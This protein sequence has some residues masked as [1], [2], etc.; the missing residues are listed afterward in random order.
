MIKFIGKFQLIVRNVLT[1]KITDTGWL[2][3]LVLDNVFNYKY[4][5]ASSASW[6]IEL[7]TGST[8]PTVADLSLETLLISKFANNPVSGAAGS[9]TDF[10]SPIYSTSEGWELVFDLGEVIGNISEIGISANNNLFTR[11]L[12]TDGSGDPTT[13]TLGAND[14]LTVNYRLG[15]E[16]DTSHPPGSVSVDF[17][18]VTINLTAKW[19]DLGKGAACDNGMNNEVFPYMVRTQVRQGF[20]IVQVIP[21][22]PLSDIDGGVTPIVYS[23]SGYFDLPGN[24]TDNLVATGSSWTKEMTY[25][26][27]TGNDT[28]DWN[29]VV[30]GSYFLDQPIILFEFDST[31]VKAANQQVTITV[32]Y[33]LQRA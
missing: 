1:G 11:A 5:P 30:L 22:D 8:P 2:D 14:I 19:V 23:S 15:Y 18:G 9:G 32:K 12:I 21:S 33:E 20:G 24:W 29:G 27:E 7:G 17:D 25:T 16:M 6:Y 26:S 28:G 3:N 31:F 4:V 10:I 13:I